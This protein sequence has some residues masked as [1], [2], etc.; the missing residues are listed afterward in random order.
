M[1]MEAAT[2]PHGTI[3]DRVW[4][5]GTGWLAFVRWPGWQW[6]R[7]VRLSEVRRIEGVDYDQI[8]PRWWLRDGEQWVEHTSRPSEA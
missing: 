7:W 4:V 6:G 1:S 2:S 8:K 5:Q 3:H